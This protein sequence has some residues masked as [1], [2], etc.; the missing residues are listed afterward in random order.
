MNDTSACWREDA[1]LPVG[2][3]YGRMAIEC[4]ALRVGNGEGDNTWRAGK[5]PVIDKVEGTDPAVV[6]C[7]L[8]GRPD[9]EEVE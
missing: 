4:P 1:C 8:G 3:P 9:R 5:D 7:L 2:E 6:A